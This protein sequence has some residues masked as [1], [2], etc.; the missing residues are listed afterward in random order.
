M[1][2]LLSV[3]ALLSWGLGDFLIQRSARKFGDWV[4]LFYIT[5]FASI[6]LFPFVYRDLGVFLTLHAVLMWGTSVVLLSAVLLD[7]EALRVGKI[8]VVEP[9]Y[10][11]EIP[12]A[13][14]LAAFVIHERLSPLQIGLIIALVA[15]L[16][17]VST[18]SLRAFA[19]TK[20]ERGIWYAVF[21]TIGMGVANFL[22]GLGARETDPLAINWFTSAFVA[23]AAFVYLAATSQLKKI[24]QGW[25]TDR[26]LIVSVGFFDNLAWVTFSYA[27][28]FIPIAIATGI[29]EGYIAFAS[30]LGIA[31]NKEQLAR[32]QWVGLILTV[33]AVTV[34]G[35]VTN[36]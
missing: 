20:V 30:A 2:I 16:F 23:A 9:I 24:S 26:R 22:F 15:G 7:F 14:F 36:R 27:M 21:A 29:S 11:L 28:L 8:S 33:I 32:H 12:V 35:F 25:R 34:L 10:A 19:R 18:R 13:A 17:L 31:F 1:G 3:A 5:A 6:V 4:A